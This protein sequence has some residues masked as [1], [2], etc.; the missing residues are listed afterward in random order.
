M[1]DWVA[2]R[3]IQTADSPRGL[4]TV[5]FAVSYVN[6]G[7]GVGVGVGCSRNATR[8]FSTNGLTLN[9]VTAT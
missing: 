1:E 5:C 3:W 2:Y 8:S 9:S 4:P 6:D 7:Y